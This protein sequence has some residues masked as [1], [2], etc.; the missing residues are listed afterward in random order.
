MFE[1][2]FKM[3]DVILLALLPHLRDNETGPPVAPS[4][5]KVGSS[6]LLGVG[7][8]PQDHLEATYVS[9]IKIEC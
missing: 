9:F 3:T 7:V 1:L 2:L 8:G 4:P 5:R 6:A